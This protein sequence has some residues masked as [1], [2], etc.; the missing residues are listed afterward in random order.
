ME[1]FELVL[2]KARI[3]EPLQR[4]LPSQLFASHALAYQ[5][6]YLPHE[7]LCSRPWL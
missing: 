2:D 6:I 7:G 5:G 3:A 1:L 4:L